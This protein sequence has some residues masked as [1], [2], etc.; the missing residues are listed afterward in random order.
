LVLSKHI[1]PYV[2]LNFKNDITSV[3]GVKEQ[4]MH[5]CSY[6]IVRVCREVHGHWYNQ[7]DTFTPL[8]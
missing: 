1:D 2:T 4:C 6:L 8:L 3:I 7:V 5:T